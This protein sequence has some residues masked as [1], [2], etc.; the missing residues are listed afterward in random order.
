MDYLKKKSRNTGATPLVLVVA[1]R[2]TTQ[3]L[4][5]Y[6]LPGHYQRPSPGWISLGSLPRERREE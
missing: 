1:V 4:L 3:V 6:T 5:Q 2:E